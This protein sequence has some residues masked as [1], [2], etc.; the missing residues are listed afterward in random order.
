MLNRGEARVKKRRGILRGGASRTKIDGY[1]L[2]IR[3]G[4]PI[5]FGHCYAVVKPHLL[6][7]HLERCPVVATMECKFARNSDPLRG[8]FRVQS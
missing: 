7:H 1:L 2:E 5:E 6:K 3:L 4:T 8:G